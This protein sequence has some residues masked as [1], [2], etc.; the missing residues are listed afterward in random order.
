MTRRGGGIPLGIMD[1]VRS[2]KT[3]THSNHLL[4]TQTLGNTCL[5]NS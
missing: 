4:A 3:F 1:H 2:S 5:I